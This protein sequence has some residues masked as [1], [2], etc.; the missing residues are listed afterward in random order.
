MLSVWCCLKGQSQR[1]QVPE[2]AAP[3]KSI[4]YFNI[5]ELWFVTY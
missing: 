5:C 4:W 1:E 3:L 2:S